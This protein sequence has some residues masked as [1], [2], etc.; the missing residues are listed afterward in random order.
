MPAIKVL[1]ESCYAMKAYIAFI[2]F[3]AFFDIGLLYAIM[4]AYILQLNE[5]ILKEI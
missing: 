4:Q 1:N 3:L 2:N 5:H